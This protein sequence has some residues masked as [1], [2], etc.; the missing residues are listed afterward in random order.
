MCQIGCKGNGDCVGVGPASDGG[1]PRTSCNTTLHQ[2]VECTSNDQCALGKLCSPS[3]VCTTGCDSTHSCPGGLACCNSL[4]VD[5]TNDPNNCGSCNNPCNVGG[6]ITCCSSTCVNLSTNVDNCSACSAAC[7]SDNVATRHCTTGK[8]APTCAFGRGDCNPNSSNDGCETDFTS[9]TNCGGCGVKCDTTPAQ[10]NAAPTCFNVP[11]GG[12]ATCKYTCKAPFDD[13]DKTAPD[14][15]GCETNLSNDK[16]NCG[17][18][19]NACTTTNNSGTS[20]ISS[21]CGHSSCN[22]NQSDCDPDT[23]NHNRNECETT[24]TDPTVA[25]GT[26]SC[27]P[28][29]SGGIVTTRTCTIPGGGGSGVCTYTCNGCTDTG[30]SG[31]SCDGTKC[32]YTCTAGNVD[33]NAGTTPDTNGCEC[34]TSTTPPDGGCCATGCEQQHTTGLTNT[35]LSAGTAQ[36]ESQRYY[37][38]SP[39]RAS[40]SPLWDQDHGMRACTAWLGGPTGIGTGSCA[41]YTCNDNTTLS[42]CATKNAG[43]A[44]T[45]QCA[46]WILNGPF[47]GQAFIDPDVNCNGCSAAGSPWN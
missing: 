17:A 46:C 36:T 21:T 4:C 9:I 32:S 34:P 13:C 33:C 8:C 3:G 10:N 31:H 19:N 15:N 45:V 43:S 47:G 28:C 38:C 22:T 1:L 12:V 25:C 30:A 11:D 39:L 18:C 7:S 24:A 42:V 44:S 5:T 37:D 23:S 41:Q 29:L 26:N 40:P 16:L 27:S 20:C 2:C 6:A 14:T 35:K